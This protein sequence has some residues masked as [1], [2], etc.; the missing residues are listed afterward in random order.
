VHVL[1]ASLQ[2]NC[3]KENV[4]CVGGCWSI[5]VGRQS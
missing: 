5:I 3:E 2:N 1:E 4:S